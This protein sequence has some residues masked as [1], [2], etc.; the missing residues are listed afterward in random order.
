MDLIAGVMCTKATPRPLLTEA[1]ERA[2]GDCLRLGW[3]RCWGTGLGGSG[4]GPS[5]PDPVRVV[6]TVSQ[7]TVVVRNRPVDDYIG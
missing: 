6:S 4:L 2:E 3:P 7:L 5:V 1:R